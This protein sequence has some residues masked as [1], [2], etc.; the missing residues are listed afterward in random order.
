MLL[1]VSDYKPIQNLCPLS[2][3]SYV[4]KVLVILGFGMSFMVSNDIF[5]IGNNFYT[6]ENIFCIEVYT[7]LSLANNYFTI[8][9]MIM[10]KFQ[11]YGEYYIPFIN[12]SNL[13]LNLSIN[14][15]I[16]QLR[17]VNKALSDIVN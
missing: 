11:V 3:P 12:L 10:S 9:N 15:R 1:T 4:L 14:E 8:G 2:K 6:R 13:I 5:F 7:L 17:S 16:R